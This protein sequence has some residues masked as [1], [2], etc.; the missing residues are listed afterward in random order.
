MSDLKDNVLLIVRGPRCQSE[1]KMV[2]AWVAQSTWQ[3][4]MPQEGLEES[5]SFSDA[6]QALVSAKAVKALYSNKPLTGADFS[7]E[8]KCF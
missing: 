6:Y 5:G 7:Y 3:S 8:Q 4:I 2:A 1:G